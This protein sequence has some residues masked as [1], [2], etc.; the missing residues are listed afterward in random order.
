MP[1]MPRKSNPGPTD[2]QEET[3]E[4]ADDNQQ[5]DSQEG[6]VDDSY[7]EDAKNAVS[8]LMPGDF[9]PMS[10][11]DLDVNADDGETVHFILTGKAKDGKLTD[12]Y[13]AECDS[14]AP[15]KPKGRIKIMIMSGADKG[16]M[17]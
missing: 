17:K 12:I 8:D 16:G 9:K 13:G 3:A 15:E 5:E 10:G 2:P 14:T 6:P 11:L 4:G 7:V 1:P